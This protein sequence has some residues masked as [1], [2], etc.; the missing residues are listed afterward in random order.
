MTPDRKTLASLLRQVAV[1]LRYVDEVYPPGLTATTPLVGYGVRAQLA[2]QT[3]AVA[4][5]LLGTADPPTNTVAVRI[6]VVADA[7]GRWSAFGWKGMDDATML[8]NVQDDLGPFAT[9]SSFVTARVPKPEPAAEV[10]GD[11]EAT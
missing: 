9:R 2:A 7:D 11:A 6:A 1:C 5:E 10:A 3:D 8:S 4:A